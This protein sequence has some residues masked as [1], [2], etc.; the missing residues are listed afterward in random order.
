MSI[1]PRALRSRVLRLATALPRGSK[2]R[3]AL[4]EMLREA[5][6]APREEKDLAK[7]NV[8]IMDWVVDGGTLPPEVERISDLRRPLTDRE[9][10]IILKWFYMTAPGDF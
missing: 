9:A 5:A 4:L 2:T 1:S 10:R 7:A 6:L 3:R 8:W